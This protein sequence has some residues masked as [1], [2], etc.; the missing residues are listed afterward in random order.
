MTA[1]AAVTETES[2]IASIKENLCLML[3]WQYG[4]E[5]EISTLPEPEASMSA[6]F[7]VDVYIALA[8]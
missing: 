4:D 1:Q 8:V 5:V 3:G 6:R 7:L 2:S